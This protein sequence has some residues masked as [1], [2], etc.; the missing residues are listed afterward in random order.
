MTEHPCA[1]VISLTRYSCLCC[2]AVSL[3]HCQLHWIFSTKEGLCV[4][5]LARHVRELTPAEQGTQWRAYIDA[6]SS[7][8]RSRALR[9]VYEARTTT[10]E[11]TST[12]RGGPQFL[13]TTVVDEREGIAIT[14]SRPRG[15]QNT[16]S[17]L[18]QGQ[19][20]FVEWGPVYGEDG[21]R[22]VPI[23]GPEPCPGCRRPPGS[24]CGCPF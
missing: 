7:I 10:P 13:L 18:Q 21:H 11:V 2:G 6:L 23:P 15:E 19:A 9:S 24:I 8:N 20:T 4:A 14:V 16:P 1:C 3:C 17:H 12:W 5:C 22:D